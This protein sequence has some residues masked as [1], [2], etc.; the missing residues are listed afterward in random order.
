VL[1]VWYARLGE[2]DSLAMLQKYFKAGLSKQIAKATAASSSELVFP[3][4]VEGSGGRLVYTTLRRPFFLPRGCVP[5]AIW[6]SPGKH[7]R[8]TAKPWPKIAAFCS[9]VTDWSTWRSSWSALA[10]SEPYAWWR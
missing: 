10:V 3:K 7:S 1:D 5:R 9:I 4:L 6:T 8:N 2:S